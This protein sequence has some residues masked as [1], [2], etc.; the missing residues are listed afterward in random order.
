MT[1]ELRKLNGTESYW[2]ESFQC[3]WDDFGREGIRLT[4]EELHWIARGLAGVA[5]NQ[6]T[7]TGSELIADPR[8]EDMEKMRKALERER[9]LVHCR[10]CD[11]TG[12]EVTSAYGRRCD[13]QCWKCQGEGKHLP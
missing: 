8:D 3:I 9:K 4:D 7:F 13:T 2:L 10:N 6:G 11:G 12:R 1:K 5:E